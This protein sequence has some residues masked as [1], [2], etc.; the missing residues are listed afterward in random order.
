MRIAASSRLLAVVG[1]PIHH[2]L[3]PVMQN[4]AITAQGLDAVY[5][6]IRA[7]SGVIAHV[8]RAFEAV[9]VAG[10]VTVPHK[11]DV[12]N[13]LI[14]LTNTAKELGAVNTFWPEGGRLIGDNT[15]VHGVLDALAALKAEGP[16]LVAGTGGAAR[17]VAAAARE[18]DMTLVVRSRSPKRARDFVA[19][20]RELGVSQVHT[21]DGRTVATAINATPLGLAPDHPRPIPEERLDGCKAALD[22]VYAPGA[23]RWIRDCRAR[24]IRA[25]DGRTMLV[26][27]GA[28]AFE[29]FFPQVTAP[30]EVMA[31]AVE[32]ALES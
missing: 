31:A 8:I 30:R 11:M 32:R 21:D 9:G 6:A 22:L 20:A 23:T 14:R 4:A 12:A 26:A 1:D 28:R 7:E 19:W 18:R 29:R 5:V 24:G 17:A 2:S 16:W 13:L 25:A 15:D 10:N 3:S 27:Q